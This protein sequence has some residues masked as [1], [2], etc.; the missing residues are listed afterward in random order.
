MRAEEIGRDPE[1]PWNERL[2]AVKWCTTIAV[3]EA[4]LRQTKARNAA[5]ETKAEDDAKKFAEV[6]S[7]IQYAMSVIHGA[8]DADSGRSES[9]AAAS[10]LPGDDEE[11]EA[12]TAFKIH[13]REE[14]PY[15]FPSQRLM[16]SDSV[17]V[18]EASTVSSEDEDEP[19]GTAN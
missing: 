11:T 3:L 5:L 13:I 1:T 4:D 8:S 17:E 14:M 2:A 16:G 10:A 7:I 9:R 19:K 18:Y 12:T 15:P 6:A